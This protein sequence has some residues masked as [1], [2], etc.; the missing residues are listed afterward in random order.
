MLPHTPKTA[1][2]KHTTQCLFCFLVYSE[3][4][5]HHRKLRLEHFHHS[6]KKFLYPLIITPQLFLPQ[7]LGINVSVSMDW[8][9]IHINR[10]IGDVVFY[11]GLLSLFVIF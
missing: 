7:Q 4:Y 1:V 2:Y 10:I 8:L 11:K 6:L 9:N 5:N 3:L